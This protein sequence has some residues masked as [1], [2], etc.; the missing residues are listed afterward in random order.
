MYRLGAP[1]HLAVS[2]HFV[3]LHGGRAR[4]PL[5]DSRISRRFSSFRR[6]S[7]FHIHPL[8]PGH[9]CMV[10]LFFRLPVATSGGGGGGTA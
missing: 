9:L 1:T 5:P 6:P 10:R 2:Q 4:L 7:L 8:T 3:F